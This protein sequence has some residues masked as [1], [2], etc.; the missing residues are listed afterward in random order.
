MKK[1][2]INGMIVIKISV[3]WIFV[4]AI[5]ATFVI[6]FFKNYIF[7]TNVQEEKVEVSVEKN[8][9]EVDILKLMVE[10]NFSNKKL[11]N[12]ERKIDFEIVKENDDQ[13]PKGEEVVVTKGEKGKKQVTALQYYGEDKYLSEEVI[14]TVVKKEPKTQVVHVGTSEF[15]AKYKV[16]IGEEMYLLEK[17][18]LKKEA[19]KDSETLTTINRYLNFEIV[20]AS[21]DWAKV[22]YKEYEGY[23]PNS[24]LTSEA[25]TPK[26][27]EQN[28]IAKLQDSLNIEMDL[29]VPSGLTLSDFKTV[30]GYNASDKNNIFSDNVEAFYNAEQ[31]YQV[32]GIF[33]AAIGI[34][35][36]AWGTS[37]IAKD[38]KNLFG[39]GAYDWSPYESAF[40]FDTYYDGIEILAKSL[41]KNYLN[42]AGT[43]LSNGEIATG[44]Y[45][46]GN[47]A[48]AVNIRYAS[49][50]EWHNK[51][52]NYLKQ[53]YENL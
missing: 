3:L 20:Q 22:K 42:P 26:I 14:E 48:S 32:N 4:L 47:T 37:Q 7:A 52:L 45:Y 21:K 12:E 38:K 50:T 16:H 1:E 25:V 8:Q 35:E 51:V 29:S 17:T 34:H 31:E 53:L 44:L 10:N 15:L 9:N 39:Y 18:E 11:V 49:D 41:S 27:K 28:R 13:I 6:A 24:K 36:S 2:K 33:L 46:N 43:I 23:L 30:L 40:S 19:N 5:I